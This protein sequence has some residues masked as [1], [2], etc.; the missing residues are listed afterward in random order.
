[1]LVYQDIITKKA[2][3]TYKE[4]D[5][6]QAAFHLLFSRLPI[7]EASGYWKEYKTNEAI[8]LAVG[9]ERVIDVIKKGKQAIYIMNIDGEECKCVPDPDYNGQ[10]YRE[11]K[12]HYM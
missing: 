3:L 10:D 9:R 5:S 6:Y 1:M 11:S 4:D 8:F 12:I 2:P 7:I